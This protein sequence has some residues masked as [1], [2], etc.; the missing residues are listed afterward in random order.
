MQ[1]EQEVPDD[2]LLNDMIARNEDEMELFAVSLKCA[3]K[4]WSITGM[5]VHAYSI[6]L[7]HYAHFSTEP[8]TL[9][10]HDTR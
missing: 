1:E 4:H 7:D 9:C 2:E 3:A 8:S 5:L 10:M 6:W